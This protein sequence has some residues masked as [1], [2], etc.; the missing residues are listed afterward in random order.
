MAFMAKRWSHRTLIITIVASGFVLSGLTGTVSWLKKKQRLA[1]EELAVADLLEFGRETQVLAFDLN[2]RGYVAP[3]TLVRPSETQPSV[4][5]IHS[6]FLLK[7]RNGY[8]FEFKGFDP[9]PPPGRYWPIEPAYQSFTYTATPLRPGVSG[10][11]MFT[12][13]SETMEVHVREDGNT[14]TSA[15]PVLPRNK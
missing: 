4:Q 12:L 1:N 6:R 5:L 2:G 8:R 3:R 14:P 13:S 15:D 11:R 9:E 7:V 10:L